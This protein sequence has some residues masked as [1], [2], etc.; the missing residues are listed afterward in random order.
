VSYQLINKSN[1]EKVLEIKNW[2]WYRLL[3]M[4]EAHGWIPMGTVMEDRLY[5]QFLSGDG[6]R[7]RQMPFDDLLFDDF[8]ESGYTG[9]SVRL[10]LIE[11]ALN[12]GDALER[13][14]IDYQPIRS[15]EHLGTYYPG[16]YETANSYIPGIGVIDV[17]SNFCF[18]GA[19]YIKFRTNL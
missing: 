7:P 10:V 9:Q 16:V 13:A 8:L 15:I 17:V 19:F 4:A 14:Y 12:L 6:Y 5:G 18:E 1:P 2:A 11:D 3:D